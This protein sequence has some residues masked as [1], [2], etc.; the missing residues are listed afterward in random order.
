MQKFDLQ[1]FE[2]KIF[3]PFD[4]N[5][6]NFT[7]QFSKELRKHKNF[8]KYIE[9]HFLSLWCSKNN[10]E[11]FYIKEN[12]NLYKIGRGLVFHI[13]PKNIP[14]NF[15]YSFFLGLLSGNSNIVKLPNGNFEETEVV[16]DVVKKLFNNK[17]FKFLKNSNFFLKLAHDSN[18]IEDITKISDARMIWGGDSTIEFYKKLNSPIRCLDLVFS[19][20]YSFSII[21]SKK[22]QE[23]NI[24]K[25]KELAKKFFVDTMLTDQNAC[26]TPHTVFWIG[27]IKRQIKNVFWTELLNIIKEK[28]K[29][30]DIQI[31]DKYNTLSTFLATNKFINNFKNYENYLYLIEVKNNINNIEKLRGINGMFFEIELSNIKSLSKFVSEKC[32]TITSFGH[33]N[34]EIFEIIKKNNLKGIDQICDFGK[35]MQFSNVWDGYNVIESLTRSINIK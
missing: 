15:I 18:E 10:I 12:E 32:Q 3:V 30:D 4:R 34:K 5:I 35:A 29:I 14:L 28:Y 13:S 8:K 31:F 25:K 22:F 27:K 20:R 6:L 2:K 11:K 23:L 1:K 16:L 17:N 33:G 7:Y 26:N 24:N 19:D 21:N 9:L